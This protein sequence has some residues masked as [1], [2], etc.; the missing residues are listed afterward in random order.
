MQEDTCIE[1]RIDLKHLIAVG[2]NISDEEANTKYNELYKT[3]F[4]FTK[5]EHYKAI[6]DDLS[7]YRSADNVQHV[8]K[9]LREAEPT[10]RTQFS[11]V[12]G[13][14]TS[15]RAHT[16]FFEHSLISVCRWKFVFSPLSI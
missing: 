10:A 4:L 3:Q 15:S 16:S 5:S 12:S 6:E 14:T 7:K 13:N 8:L 1:N 9:F 11:L 2:L